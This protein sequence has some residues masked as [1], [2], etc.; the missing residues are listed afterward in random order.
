[1]F[2]YRCLILL[3]T[4]V[5]LQQNHGGRTA[6]VAFSGVAPGLGAVCHAKELPGLG[7]P[8]CRTTQRLYI[9][10]CCPWSL[11]KKW[12]WCQTYRTP[13]NP[14]L[15]LKILNHPKLFYYKTP[16]QPINTISTHYSPPRRH[17]LPCSP[18][19]LPALPPSQGGCVSK[20]T[21]FLIVALLTFSDS[22]F[23]LNPC[24]SFYNSR[25]ARNLKPITLHTY[26]LKFCARKNSCAATLE[27]R[28]A[29][30]AHLILVWKAFLER[31]TE[32]Q[33]TCLLPRDDGFRG[34]VYIQQVASQRP[35]EAKK[36]H[37][38]F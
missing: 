12:I 21:L 28:I 14:N 7:H 3:N 13:T 2:S 37:G 31:S 30:C 22:T 29:V 16:F 19:G 36:K 1:M 24:S 10:A 6:A 11:Q 27:L 15:R 20:Q 8:E 5:T 34:V 35:A 9:Y 23:T 32:E 25:H 4:S 38:P 17:C 18:V 33:S 26:K